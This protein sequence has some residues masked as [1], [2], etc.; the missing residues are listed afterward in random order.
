MPEVGAVRHDV[1][2]LSDDDIYLFGEGTHE[3]IYDKLGAHPMKHEGVD[4]TYFAVW[5]PSATYVGV[6][7][8]FNGWDNAGHPLAVRGSSGVWEGFVPGVAAGELYKFHIGGDGGWSQDKA[9]PVGQSLEAAPRTAAVVPDLAYEWHDAAWMSERGARQAH[10]APVSIYEVHLGSWMRNVDERDRAMSY[11]ELAPKLAEHV[12]R[13]GFTHVELLPVMEHPFY[14]SWGYQVTGYFAAS[15]RYGS[16][17]D[18][19]ALIDHLHGEGIGVILDWVPSHF[20]EDAHALAFFDGT[21]L[22]EH[23]DPRQGFHPDWSS[24]IF[25]YG[26]NEVASFLVSSAVYWLDRF[27]A[28]GLRVD[29][30]ASMLYR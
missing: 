26:R 5:A 2:R 27:H 4:G 11:R 19:M 1:S 28:D 20:P 24:A 14:G 25:N 10:D 6:I 29:G 23:A 18:L 9:D 13:L 16:P 30:V 22:Y 8:D 17:T 7:G 15:A 12:R 3:R 21:H